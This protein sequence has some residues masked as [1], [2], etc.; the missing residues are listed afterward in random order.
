MAAD[1]RRLKLGQLSVAR[2]HEAAARQRPCDPR[3]DGI[4]DDVR[5]L[6]CLGHAQRDA[7]VRVRADVVAHDA[8]GP[9]RRE[10]EMDP[11]AAPALGDVDDAVD[12]LRD[13]ALEGRELVDDDHERRGRD[14]GMAPLELDEVFDAVLVEDLLALAQLGVEREQRAPDQV[15]VQVGH[16]PHRVR[17][18]HAVLER[19]SALVVDEQEAQPVGRV[20]ERQGR[21]ERLQQLA[22]AGAGRARDERVRAVGPEIQRQRTV[23]AVPDRGVDRRSGSCLP[24]LPHRSGRDVDEVEQLEQRHRSRD[25]GGGACRARVANRREPAG[26]RVGDRGVHP[27]GQRRVDLPAVL[28]PRDRHPRAL[29]GERHDRPAAAGDVATVATEPDHR[30][31]QGLGLR[32]DV[33]DERA[34]GSDALVQDHDDVRVALSPPGEAVAVRVAALGCEGGDRMDERGR[35][36]RAD[37]EVV[38]VQRRALRAEVRQPAQRPPGGRTLVGERRRDHDVARAVQRRR[39]QRQPAAE[40]V[41]ARGIAGEPDADRVGQA[42]DERRRGEGA[43]ARDRRLGAGAI[44]LLAATPQLDREL[45]R[46]VGGPQPQREE[47]GVRAPA[48]PQRGEMAVGACQQLGGIRGVG[49]QRLQLRRAQ[50]LQLALQAGHA[51]FELRLVARILLAPA[52]AIGDEGRH[53]H[54]RSQQREQQHRRGLEHQEHRDPH[55]HRAERC[56][57]RQPGRARRVRRRG[58]LDVR[59]VVRAGHPRRAVEVHGS[60]RGTGGLRAGGRGRPH[61]DQAAAELDVIA[62]GDEPR[63]AG[64]QA[65]AVDRGPV[66]RARVGDRRPA[67]HDVDREVTARDRRVV[68]DDPGR[69]IAPELVPAGTERHAPAGVQPSDE[70]ELDGR[71]RVREARAGWLGVPD[72]PHHV[73]VAQLGTRERQ[74]GVEHAEARRREVRGDAFAGMLGE[75]LS[76]RRDGDRR[77]ELGDE[78]A[79]FVSRAAGQTE[80]KLGALTL[81]LR[82]PG[83]RPGDHLAARPGALSRSPISFNRRRGRPR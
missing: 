18:P 51:L 62:R 37:G 34:R 44:G 56:D 39:L 46:P 77:I 57:E 35:L 52:A 83:R 26:D 43:A 28:R 25:V 17:Q 55:Q 24:A 79:R 40:G 63:L 74:I 82:R 11:E 19:G 45:C 66:A 41:D 36:V 33:L 59:R 53:R 67:G 78:V 69:G 48:L 38:V 60:G 64:F 27:V 81:R 68:D 71:R 22:L 1:V 4:A 8:R 12:E 32:E 31:V 58:H 73:A 15:G 61:H 54:D 5:A 47:V 20:V 2:A 50:L 13:L 6:G 10:N 29:T 14:I 23:A 30:D 70:R 75:R 9:L 72:E 76:E 16:H 42:R 65:M 49:A 80:A 21:H 3:R 7:Q